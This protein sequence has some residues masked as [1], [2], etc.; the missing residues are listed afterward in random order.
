MKPTHICEHIN[1]EPRTCPLKW[2]DCSHAQRHFPVSQREGTLCDE[3]TRCPFL[4]KRVRC[5]RPTHLLKVQPKGK[6]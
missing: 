2:G 6:K 1:A 4:R 3:P 5:I